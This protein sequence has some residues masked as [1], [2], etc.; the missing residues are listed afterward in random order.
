MPSESPFKPDTPANADASAA[1][2]SSVLVK[3]NRVI[4]T[5]RPTASSTANI[6]IAD[7]ASTEPRSRR[8]FSA[9]S[10]GL[11]FMI[12]PQTFERCS[13]RESELAIITGASPGLDGFRIRIHHHGFGDW[14]GRLMLAHASDSARGA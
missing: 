3:Y 13:A 11:L 7:V 9:C 5:P 8:L 12:P 1:F 14:Q 2:C 4:S 10:T 6:P